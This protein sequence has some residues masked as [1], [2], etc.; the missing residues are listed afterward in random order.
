MIYSDREGVGRLRAAQIDLGSLEPRG[1]AVP[2]L[3]DVRYMGSQSA[4]PY[5][6]VSDN[7]TA[8]YVSQQI[9]DASILWV[10][11]QGGT[12]AIRS[13][14]EIVAGIRLAPDGR[15]A[16]FGDEQGGVWLLDLTRGSIDV[17]VRSDELFS[18]Y[19]ILHPDGDRI[20][21][22]SNVGGSWSLYAVDLGSRGSSEMLLDRDNNQYPASMS[23][24]GRL[25][26]FVENHPDTNKDIWVLDEAGEATPIVR[27]PADESLPSLSPDGELIAYIS[28]ESG[29]RQVYVQRV[30]GSERLEVSLEGG[31]QPVW[32][33]DGAELFFRRGDRLLSVRVETEP[34]LAATRPVVLLDMPFEA[35]SGFSITP[36]YDVSADGERFLVVSER[37]TTE[38]QVIFNWFEELRELVPVE[39]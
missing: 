30:T 34:R 38:F 16:V 12:T 13:G 17:A 6:A 18:I 35:G 23:A 37:P 4:I 28:E 14:P 7:G 19:P 24:D 36:Y 32:S 5:L 1:Q 20:V 2:V 33:R 31:S 9:G 25:L 11:R 29:A 26:A 21:V 27:T 15:R 39:D 3:D 8:V 22:T 10:D